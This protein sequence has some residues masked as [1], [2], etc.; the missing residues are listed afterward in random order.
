[1]P[2]ATAPFCRITPRKGRF[3]LPKGGKNEP[4]IR[5]FS[6]ETVNDT[7]FVFGMAKVTLSVLATD[8]VEVTDRPESSKNDARWMQVARG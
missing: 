8:A 4:L 2:S 7:R 1:M 5:P 3:F 6:R